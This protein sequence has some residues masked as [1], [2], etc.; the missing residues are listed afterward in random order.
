MQNAKRQAA[1][2]WL[3]GIGQRIRSGDFQGALAALLPAVQ[4]SDA[5]PRVFEYTAICFDALRDHATAQALIAAAVA[6]FPRDVWLWALKAR[7]EM[8]SGATSEAQS[9]LAQA[10]KIAPGH[11][12]ALTTLNLLSPFAKGSREDRRLRRAIKSADHS[13]RELAA[14][15]NGIARIEAASGNPKGAFFHFSRCNRLR[16][17]SYDP[18][19]DIRD[20]A[21]QGQLPE[22]PATE[23]TS[24]LFVGGMPRSGT[25]VLEA[26]LLRHPQVAS[27]G[28]T[29]V[30]ATLFARAQTLAGELPEG[31][32]QLSETHR[33]ELRDQYMSLIDPARG[34]ASVVIEKMPLACLYFGFARWLFPEARFVYMDRH[35][36]DCG[37]SNFAANFDDAHAWSTKLE[38]IAAKLRATQEAARNWADRLGPDFHRQSFRALVENPEA[39]LRQVLEH[40]GLEWHAACLSP[41]DAGNLRTASL[42]Q[43]REGFNRKGLGKWRQYETQLAPLIEALGGHAVVETWEEMDAAVPACAA[44]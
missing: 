7:L 3:D 10:L 24:L 2:P 29:P 43:V 38:W 4:G 14:A 26:A 18:E 15:H 28:E 12:G 27:L 40:V 6:R 44:E 11:L 5:G 39:S 25:T 9:S 37:L 23:Q 32:A 41:Q 19:K 30:L 16:G 13:A 34:T 17:G 1:D 31:L 20:I 35:P 8:Q 22:F 42:L 36:L 33:Q 21:A